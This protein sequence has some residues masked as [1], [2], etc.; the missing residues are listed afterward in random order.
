MP[1]G[2]AQGATDLIF[3]LQ[4]AVDAAEVLLGRRLVE[5]CTDPTTGQIVPVVVTGNGPAMKSVAAARGFAVRRG[6]GFRRGHYISEACGRVMS[7]H[8][9]IGARH[10]SSL[11]DVEVC[12]PGHQ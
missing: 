4:S 12:S 2:D 8:T 1:R 6:L 10:H 11:D 7:C 9:T 5:D 3:V